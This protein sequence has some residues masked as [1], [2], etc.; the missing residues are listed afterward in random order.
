M[1]TATQEFTEV[2]IAGIKEACDS[3]N[4][5][6]AELLYSQPGH[7]LARSAYEDLVS[8]ARQRQAQVDRTHFV[9]NALTA[10]RECLDRYDFAA[11]DQLFHGS[12]LVDRDDYLDLKTP[13]V[14]QVVE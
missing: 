4:Y 7:T 2:T 11:A 12:D 5:D 13:Y 1:A 3:R 14:W 10:I 8:K 9:A 6:R